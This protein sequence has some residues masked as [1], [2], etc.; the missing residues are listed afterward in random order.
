MVY[1]PTMKLYAISDIHLSYASNREA[2]EALPT[3]PEDWLIL[4][5][6]VGETEEHLHFALSLLTKR[7][8]GLLWVPGNHDLWSNPTQPGAL[9]GEAGLP[10]ELLAKIHDG[11]FG[12]THLRALA[13]CLAGIHE[14]QPVPVPAYS[15]PAALLRNLALWLVILAHGFRRVLP[16]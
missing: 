4:A 2:L 16:F 15:A 3:Y 10:V 5:G 9:H 6:D 7:F 12:P 1:F 11:P 8:A 13:R 14:G